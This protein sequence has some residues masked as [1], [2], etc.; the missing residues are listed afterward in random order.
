MRGLPVIAVVSRQ[1]ARPGVALLQ[2]AVKEPCLS[3]PMDIRAKA[4]RIVAAQL[5]VAA[6]IALGLWVFDGAAPAR[7]ALV[8]GLISAA[9]S[10]LFGRW[11][12]KATGGSPRAFAR[13]F[14]LGEGLKIVLTVALFWVAI[15]LLEAGLAP[16]FI[17]YAATLIV[18]WLALL[19]ETSGARPQQRQ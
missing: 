8:G 9:G 5:A 16:L 11:L 15:A 2:P 4:Y 14:Y 18:Y 3:P 1:P 12:A 10:L 7:S 19:P 17:T 6:V 13:A